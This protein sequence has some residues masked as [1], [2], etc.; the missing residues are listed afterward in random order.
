MTRKDEAQILDQLE[1]SCARAE[2]AGKDEDLIVALRA[3]YILW[4]ERKKAIDRLKE[5]IAINAFDIAQLQ[6]ELEKAKENIRR[7]VEKA[8]ERH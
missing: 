4:R 8:S 6:T 1:N 5:E 7:V 3:V 2:K